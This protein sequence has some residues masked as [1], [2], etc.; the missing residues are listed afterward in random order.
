MDKVK[1]LQFFFR[2]KIKRIKFRSRIKCLSKLIPCPS[3]LRVGWKK[4]VSLLQ[5][6]IFPSVFWF[7]FQRDSVSHRRP[8]T[9]FNDAGENVERIKTN[10]KMNWQRERERAR[11]REYQIS[12]S[13]RLSNVPTIEWSQ[14][15]F[16]CRKMFG[17]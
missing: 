14:F 7:R 9:G 4:R 3:S 8:G 16:Y 11:E 13:V 17:F 1:L 5:T 15:R 6:T 12:K 2:T 10:K